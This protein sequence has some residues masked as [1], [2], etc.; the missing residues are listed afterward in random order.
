VGPRSPHAR[1]SLAI[2]DLQK[3]RVLA[4]ACM[5][6][7]LAAL[8]VRL[9]VWQLGRYHERRALNA[10]MFE[11]LAKA[12]VD[13][14][15]R[16]VPPDS[17]RQRRVRLRGRFDERRQVL[18]AG[19]FHAGTP[20]VHVLT[21]FLPEGGTLEVLV[22]RG[23]LEADDAVTAQPARYPVAGVREVVGLAATLPAGD[24]ALPIRTIAAG[25]DTLLSVASLGVTAFRRRLGPALADYMITALPEPPGSSPP[26]REAPQ[27]YPESMHL[28]YAVQW[29]AFAAILVVGSLALAFMRR[30]GR[31]ASSARPAP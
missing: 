1:L 28:G 30:G 4:I 8:C 12:P 26:V 3:P 6:V 15:G 19:Q 25:P 16:S 29:F 17:L 2:R 23:W 31:D 20:G 14:T 18:L 5:V 24:P 9:G 21:P 10:A 13:I 7:A 11:R 27:P 22:D